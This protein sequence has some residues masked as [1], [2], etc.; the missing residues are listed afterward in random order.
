MY[1]NQFISVVINY[2]TDLLMCNK[3]MY[4]I[5]IR[6]HS[7]VTIIDCMVTTCTT[8]FKIFKWWMNQ[9]SHIYR[10]CLLVYLQSPNLSLS[11]VL[12]SSKEP[13]LPPIFSSLPSPVPSLRKWLL[14]LVSRSGATLFRSVWNTASFSCSV[15]LRQIVL[16]WLRAVLAHKGW[17]CLKRPL[18]VHQ[19]QLTP[20]AQNHSYKPPTLHFDFTHT[21][22]TWA[23]Y[24]DGA[25]TQTIRLKYQ[26]THTQGSSGV[27]LYKH[28][29]H[30][31]EQIYE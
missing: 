17:L 14:A 19:H 27:S 15:G 25:H 7:L 29:V 31:V 26:D 30:F 2:K 10:S 8:G 11:F 18:S 6:I 20:T 12:L 24:T 13:V 28:K 21:H 22:I 23:M 4:G 16:R 9:H 5:I 1:A 3:E